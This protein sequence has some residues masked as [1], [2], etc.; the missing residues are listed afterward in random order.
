M[1]HSATLWPLVTGK[2]H[3]RGNST[4]R[5]VVPIADV[6]NLNGAVVIGTVSS[7]QGMNWPSGSRS[8]PDVSTSLR[9]LFPPDVSEPEPFVHHFDSLPD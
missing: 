8:N 2:R 9:R 7:E 5:I 1:R 3:R 4:K 6:F